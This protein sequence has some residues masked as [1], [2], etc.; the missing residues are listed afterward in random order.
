VSPRVTGGPRGQTDDGHPDVLLPHQP[1]VG[2]LGVVERGSMGTPAIVGRASCHQA[3]ASPLAEATTL[4]VARCPTPGNNH[5]PRPPLHPSTGT[6]RLPPHL[7][8]AALSSRRISALFGNQTAHASRAGRPAHLRNA[9]P[10]FS[11][12]CETT[13]TGGHMFF[14][15]RGIAQEECRPWG[16]GTSPSPP[17]FSP[18]GRCM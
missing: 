18:M 7:F 11:R 9:L 13:R 5:P 17:T 1:T 12:C 14:M 10:G 15:G 6:R 3:V 8:Q 4:L 2:A 16:P